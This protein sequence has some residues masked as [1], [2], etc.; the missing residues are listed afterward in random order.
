M[1]ASAVIAAV[2]AVLSVVWVTGAA[3][4]RLEPYGLNFADCA[5]EEGRTYCG[6]DLAARQARQRAVNRRIEFLDRQTRRLEALTARQE[7][8]TARQEREN[9]RLCAEQFGANSSE[10]RGY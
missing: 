4:Y 1:K 9:K 7:R 3:D 6:D 8:E 5:R 2:V 10:C